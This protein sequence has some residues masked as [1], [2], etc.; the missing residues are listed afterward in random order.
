[1][2]FGEIGV[3]C[4]SLFHCLMIVYDIWIASVG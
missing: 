3:T 2:E 1:M 4:G